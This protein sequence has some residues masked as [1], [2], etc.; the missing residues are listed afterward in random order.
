[1]RSLELPST[2]SLVFLLSFISL[3][4]FSLCISLSY[5]PIPFLCSLLSGMV[6]HMLYCSVIMI[7]FNRFILLVQVTL[8]LACIRGV[9]SSRIYIT[10]S[11]RDSVSTYFGKQG[12]TWSIT[13][14]TGPTLGV[15][16]VDLLRCCKLYR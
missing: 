5:H 15:S 3:I 16:M 9:F 7:H 13:D 10:D 6:I 1:V 8:G 2:R 4:P 12:V 11:R 14:W